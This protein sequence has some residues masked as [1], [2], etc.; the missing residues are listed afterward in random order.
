[1]FLY[2]S[3]RATIFL[4]IA[5]SRDTIGPRLNARIELNRTERD[6]GNKGDFM[7]ISGWV[8]NKEG[9]VIEVYD[10]SGTSPYWINQGQSLAY[11][12]SMGTRFK[13]AAFYSRATAEAL[14]A[15]LGRGLSF[16]EY[17]GKFIVA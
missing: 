12:A 17:H 10:V 16:N 5:G 7:R 9:G 13:C 11:I 1:M 14:A 15:A 6:P 8:E 4:D 3:I 2:F